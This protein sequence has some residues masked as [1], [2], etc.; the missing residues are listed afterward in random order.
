MV[1]WFSDPLLT[2]LRSYGYN[3]ILLP[4]T[5]VKPLQILSK[6]SKYLDKLGNLTTILVAGSNI[7]VPKI[8]ENQAA[9]N[10][11]GQRTSYLKIGVGLSI[12]GNI[13]SAMGG[14]F[15]GLEGV[16]QQ[17]KTI[18]F[19]FN[20]VLQDKVDV[21]MLDQYLSDADVS[22]FSQ[23]VGQLLE[24]DDVYVITEIIKSRKFTVSAK[25]SKNADV[26]LNIPVI[27]GVVG[28]NVTVS[29]QAEET[30]KITYEGKNTP[31]VFGFQAIRLFY[32]NGRYQKLK[33]LEPSIGMRDL[34]NVSRQDGVE[35]LMTEGPFASI[36]DK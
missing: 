23:Y 8:K 10:I 33:P 19:E 21:A 5:D 13:I 25:T 1:L 22:P 4:K 30:S 14:K 34:E 26:T 35:L 6:N 12:L 9:A 27:Q 18:S 32:S 36:A 24:A 15:L 7:A 3:V 31:L 29:A 16:Y 20:D 17:A 11:S 28:G 2:Y